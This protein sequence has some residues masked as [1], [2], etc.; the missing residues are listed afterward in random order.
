MDQTR[1]L[2]DLLIDLSRASAAEG[3][4]RDEDN[5]SLLIWF[6]SAKGTRSEAEVIP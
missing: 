5:V 6:G 4:V 2:S 1:A 3:G